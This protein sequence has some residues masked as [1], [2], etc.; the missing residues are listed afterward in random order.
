[1]TRFQLFIEE[2]KPEVLT[3]PKLRHKEEKN[4]ILRMCHE[5]LKRIRTDREDGLSQSV[6]IS[7]TIK[8]VK[9]VIPHTYPSSI[10]QTLEDDNQSKRK[11][12]EK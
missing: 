6:L 9:Q 2:S 4:K 3:V 7:N 1:M 8:V 10:Y 11:E 12:N 5:K